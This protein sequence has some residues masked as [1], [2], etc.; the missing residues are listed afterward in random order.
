MR[1]TSSSFRESVLSRDEKE[2]LRELHR[3]GAR[4][5]RE[6]T[7]LEVRDE[8]RADRRAIEA[9]VLGEPAV[10]GREHGDLHVRAD[11]V[12]RRP[13]VGAGPGGL[14]ADRA[15]GQVDAVRERLREALAGELGA[16]PA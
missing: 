15:V 4:A 10:L 2:V 11:L 6:A 7:G 12:E 3:D 13:V 5:A 14:L 9:V 1:T 8:R 16:G